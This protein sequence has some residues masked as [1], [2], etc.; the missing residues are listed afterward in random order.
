MQTTVCAQVI[1]HLPGKAAP[2]RADRVEELVP[3]DAGSTPGRLPELTPGHP[4]AGRKPF[5]GL[6]GPPGRAIKKDPGQMVHAAFELG[7]RASGKRSPQSG[8][9]GFA[10]G[11]PRVDRQGR[12]GTRTRSPPER[13]REG[14]YSRPVRWCAG[15]T[16]VPRD[17]RAAAARACQL[18]VTI[19]SA[20]SRILSAS[21]R[22]AIPGRAGRA[23]APNRAPFASH[24]A[25]VLPLRGWPQAMQALGGRTPARRSLR[26]P[27]QIRGRRARVLALSV[28]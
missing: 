9:T 2:G 26:V 22:T 25:R 14:R 5:V 11:T 12:S 8:T 19:P 20:R 13:A 27:D 15:W 4:V 16:V 23:E 3:P 18:S 24:P 6:R 21:R 7:R 17:S 1:P 28:T 10:P